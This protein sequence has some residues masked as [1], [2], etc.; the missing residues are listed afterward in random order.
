MYEYVAELVRVVDGDTVELK[1]TKEIDFG[2]YVKMSQTYQSKFRLYGIDTPE[3][4]GSSQ[5]DR[6]RGLLA[7][8]RLEHL[9]IGKIRVITYKADKYGR[10]LVDL[11]VINLDGVEIF[12]N[13]ELIKEGLAIAYKP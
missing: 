3:I 4:Y 1:V 10:W 6:S 8:E 12:V 2:F 5:E 9:L 11:Y 13:Q 7:K